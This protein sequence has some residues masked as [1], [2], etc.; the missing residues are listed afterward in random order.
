MILLYMLQLNWQF[1]FSG[2]IFHRFLNLCFPHFCSFNSKFKVCLK[3]F[4]QVWNH[5]TKSH[6]FFV[7]ISRYF[8]CAGVKFKKILIAKLNLYLNQRLWFEPKLFNNNFKQTSLFFMFCFLP[9]QW[10]HSFPEEKCLVICSDCLYKQ[11]EPRKSALDLL[12]CSSCNHQVWPPTLR[13][14]FQELVGE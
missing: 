5:F 2:L 11:S 10:C 1:T 8:T 3:I 7:Y 6:S 14:F 13:I 12:Y 4:K 9:F